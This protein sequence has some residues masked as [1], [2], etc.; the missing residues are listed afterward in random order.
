MPLAKDAFKNATAA[1]ETAR[2]GVSIVRQKSKSNQH[3]QA[4]L[5]IVSNKFALLILRLSAVRKFAILVYSAKFVVE[6]QKNEDGARCRFR[7]CDPYRVKVMLY[8]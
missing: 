1:V 3:H 5:P 2:R 4:S 7:T 8:H 6:R